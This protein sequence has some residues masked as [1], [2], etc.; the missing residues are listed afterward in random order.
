MRIFDLYKKSFSNI[1]TNPTITM[2]FVLFLIL[3]NSIGAYM[4]NSQN[5][6]SGVLLSFCLFALAIAF[7]SGW[8]FVV[9][10][11]AA[12]GEKEN[13]NY[14]ALFLEGIGKNIVSITIG[15]FIYAFLFVIILF[16]SGKIAYHFFGSLDFIIKD[17]A[18]LPQDT[19]QLMEYLEN[20][21]VNQKYTIYCWQLCLMAA[22]AIFNL[23][24][25]YYF[26]SII[27]SD[28]N[29][30]LKP[31]ISFIEAVKFLFKNFVVSLFLYLTIYVI[32][33]I[34]GLLS[35]LF[36]QNPI[37]SILILILHIYF[38]CAVVMLIFS[39][40]G[41]KYNCNN[42]CDSIGENEAI[43]RDGKED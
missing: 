28:K 19:N 39:Y 6:I 13:K 1:V 36:F 4:A 11:I 29:I 35:A 18:N 22:G 24:F 3:S 30:F 2:F 10:E 31:F 8:F 15:S 17:M 32:Y 26:P 21:T 38:V 37:I 20:L 34:L 33:F 16:A 42:G 9:K 25:L 43:N 5:T 14:F 7:L 27:Y 41:Q 40:Y 12:E 23:I